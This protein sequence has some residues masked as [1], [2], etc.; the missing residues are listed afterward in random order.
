M[1]KSIIKIGLPLFLWGG[2]LHLSPAQNTG[3]STPVTTSALQIYQQEQLS[4]AQSLHALVAQGATS[5]QIRAWQIQNNS[6]LRAQRERA[7]VMGTASASH[8]L[9]FITEI[10]I[11]AG[12]PLQM[13]QILRNRATLANNFAQIHN[14]NLGTNSAGGTTDLSQFQQQNGELIQSQ[15]AQIHSFQPNLAPLSISRP[16]TFPANVTPPMRAYLTLRDQLIKEQMASWN[17]SPTL[18]ANA[19]G[20]AMLQWQQ[21]HAADLK[22]LQQLALQF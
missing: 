18:D 8:P 11:P 17:K 12:T 20:A 3:P 15:A 5:Q 19:R 21:A 22:K 4:L 16:L 1:N 13:E 6:R 2:F 10:T 14:Q 9:P 7:V